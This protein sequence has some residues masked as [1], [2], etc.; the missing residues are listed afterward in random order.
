MIR[1]E[2]GI[3][4]PRPHFRE[5]LGKLFDLPLADL[6]LLPSTAAHPEVDHPPR[7]EPIKDDPARAPVPGNAPLDGDAERSGLSFASIAVDAKNEFW[8]QLDVFGRRRDPY[9]RHYAQFFYV[10]PGVIGADPSFDITL[11]STTTKPVIL[12]DI[13]VEIV[14]VAHA[15]P[16]GAPGG[17]PKSVKIELAG[18]YTIDMPDVRGKIKDGR[19]WDNFSPIDWNEIVS[20]RLPDPIYVQAEAPYRY[21]LLLHRYSER[22]PN[23]VILR[24]WIRTHQGQERSREIYVEGR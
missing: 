4:L 11:L 20:V 5:R 15:I 8:I 19:W 21:G 22:M 24:M 16:I 2:R 7:P 13:G 9:H 14:S 10:K 1:W 3:A 17:G 12:T 18:S 6:G 23:A